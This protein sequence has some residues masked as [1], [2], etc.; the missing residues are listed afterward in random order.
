MNTK[1]TITIKT[2][3]KLRDAAKRTAMK[4]GI[5]LSTVMNAQLAQFVSEGR[6]EVSLTP[7]PERVR[8]WERIS[9][10]MDQHPERYKVFTNA[11][12]LLVDL[13]LA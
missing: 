3:K 5:P 8:A 12:D 2:D 1:T 6:F 9:E 13:G 7:R 11:D 10:E 4:L